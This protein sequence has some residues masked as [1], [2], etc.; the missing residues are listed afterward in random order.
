LL[1]NPN[2]AQ[3]LMALAGPVP[4]PKRPEESEPSGTSLSW[5]EDAFAEQAW[6][7]ALPDEDG[8]D[9]DADLDEDADEEDDDDDE[10]E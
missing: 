10:G 8:P 6:D 5:S 3:Y 7:F 9:D 2:I 1:A 4:L